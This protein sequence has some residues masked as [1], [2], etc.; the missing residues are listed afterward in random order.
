[1][2]LGE[3][4]EAKTP[5]D[6]CWW[7]VPSCVQADPLGLGVKKLLEVCAPLLAQAA[8]SQEWPL[9]SSPPAPQTNLALLAET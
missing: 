8:L 7:L 3:A 6:I 5:L 9:L 1:M 4:G 2:S